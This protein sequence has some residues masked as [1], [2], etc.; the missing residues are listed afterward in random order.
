MNSITRVAKPVRLPLA[1]LGALLATLWLSTPTKA[2]IVLASAQPPSTDGQEPTSTPLGTEIELTE[3]TTPQTRQAIPAQEL[4]TGDL[5]G[6]ALNPTK[7]SPLHS[8]ASL[9]LDFQAHSSQTGSTHAS[10]AH[11]FQPLAQIPDSIKPNT[12]PPNQPLP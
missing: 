11:P 10:H 1:T 9:E 7:S 12:I 2:E 8:P 4:E 5:D 3:R 6:V